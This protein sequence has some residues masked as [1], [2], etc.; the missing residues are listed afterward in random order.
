MMQYHTTENIKIV[1]NM[2]IS[3]LE[4]G[5]IQFT[6]LYSMAPDVLVSVENERQIKFI[7]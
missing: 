5:S 3:Y 2:N 6:E 1:L 7:K 4:D